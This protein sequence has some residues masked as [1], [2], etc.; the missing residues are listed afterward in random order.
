MHQIGFRPHVLLDPTRSFRGV[1]PKVSLLEA[2]DPSRQQGQ[3]SLP[4]SLRAGVK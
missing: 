4:G 2:Y 1:L 3:L